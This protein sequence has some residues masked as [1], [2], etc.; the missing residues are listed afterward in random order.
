[1]NEDYFR[2]IS[3]GLSGELA[4]LSIEEVLVHFRNYQANFLLDK[5]LAV[6]YL[7]RFLTGF[8]DEGAACAR[9]PLE[10]LLDKTLQ[11]SPFERVNI[12]TK[13][14]MDDPASRLK[15]E[16][17]DRTNTQ[18]ETFHMIEGLDQ[19]RDAEDIVLFLNTLLDAYPNYAL[20]AGKLLEADF[21]MGRL[22]SS[23]LPKFLCPKR[24]QDDFN[25]MLFRHYAALGQLDEAERLWATLPPEDQREVNLNFAAEVAS[26]RGDIPRAVD[27][28]QRSLALDPAQAPVRFR[29]AELSSPSRKRPELVAQ[30]KVAIYLYSYNKAKKLKA[31]LASL[32][33]SNIGPAS[34]TVLLNGCTDDSLAV[35]Q[36]AQKLFPANTFTIIPLHVNIGAPAARN[37]LINLPSTWESDYVAFLDDDVDVPEDWLEWYL[38]V[39]EGDAKIAVVG[40]KVV[41]PGHPAKYQ[42]LFRYV[43]VAR[44]DLLKLCLPVPQHQYDNGAYD[45]IRETRSVMGCLHLLRTEALRKVPSFD[46]RFSPSQ[47]DDIDHDLC[48]CL[49]GYKVMYCGLVTCV[50]HQS[51]GTGLHSDAADFARTGNSVG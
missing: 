14:V 30:K 39:A 47:V 19:T 41:F 23:W 33:G 40:G 34:I 7:N 49:A 2:I 25:G 8:N 24:L 4:F 1:M 51:S 38:T 26:Q 20:A 9:Q 29:L 48:L 6:C 11:L 45:F 13:A 18:A 21:V 12:R 15:V 37:W 36:W 32:A 44:D 5:D 16:I 10:Y 50:H 28:Y 17:L 35:A 42:Y 43:S 46:I 27:L 31:T 22:P 3:E